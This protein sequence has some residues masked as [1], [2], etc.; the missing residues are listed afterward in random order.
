MNSEYLVRGKGILHDT[1]SVSLSKVTSPER[2][3][4]LC[5]GTITDFVLVL[6]TSEN[7]SRT[8]SFPCF[9][10]PNLSHSHFQDTKLVQSP[11]RGVTERNP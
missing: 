10:L 6:P 3:S 2:S 8:L 4:D 11:L 9:H 7:T 5:T 1:I